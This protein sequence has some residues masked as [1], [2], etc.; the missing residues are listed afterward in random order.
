MKKLLAACVVLLCSAAPASAGLI[1]TG[2]ID[3][4]LSGGTP[5]AIELYVTQD[6]ADLSIYGVGSAN[7]GGG[8]DGEEFTLSGTATEGDFIYIA[9]EATEFANFFGFGPDFTSG[10]MAI[11]G[12]DA[13]E[14]FQNGSVIDI[15]G[16]INVDGSGE[17]WEYADGWAYRN[18]DTGPDG[19]TFNIGSW[20]FS[21]VD[22]LDGATSNATAANAFPIGSYSVSVPEPSSLAFLAVAFAGAGLIR[23][24]A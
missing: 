13:I 4:P 10:A 22:A 6:I 24:R 23:R 3:G 17:P 15:F 18:D 14:V 21:G 5:K 20:T 1:L 7:N 16:D 19:S 12:D 11:N 9:S 8:T 2:V